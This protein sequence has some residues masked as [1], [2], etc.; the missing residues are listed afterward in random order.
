MS[1][2]RPRSAS[3][4]ASWMVL[5]VL[6]TLPFW[7]PTAMTTVFLIFSDIL[8][9]C[10]GFTVLE[11]SETRLPVIPKSYHMIN[12]GPFVQT[13]FGPR[14]LRLV[15]LTC[16]RGF[17]LTTSDFSKGAELVGQGVQPTVFKDLFH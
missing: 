12:S 6:P 3:A 9:H 16:L 1:E 17:P 2:R 4:P 10:F 7:F 11:G 14:M 13:S 8:L 15:E 5:V